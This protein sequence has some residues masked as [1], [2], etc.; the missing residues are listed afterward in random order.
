MRALLVAA[1]LVAS[2][3]LP[4]HA[5]ARIPPDSAA[6]YR[7]QEFVGVLNQGDS[8][9][10][11][12][13]ISQN[14]APASLERLPLD[15]F[16]QWY[17][18][19][20]NRTRGVD[21]IRMES[22]PTRADALLRGHLF[23]GWETLGL[24]LEPKPP[25]RII[26]D[27]TPDLQAPTSPSPPGTDR[28]RVE[29]L[30]SVLR[31]LSDA[32]AFSGVVLLARADSVLF[33]IA[34]GPED[35]ENDRPNQMDTR[36][37]LG[38]ITKS[39]TAVAVAQL[40]EA[41]KLS[42]D[43]PLTTYFPHFPVTGAERVL[44][45]HLLSHTSGVADNIRVC[46]RVKDCPTHPRTIDDYVRQVELAQEETLLFRP[47]TAWNYSN[48]N[49]DLLG[50][51][52]ELVSGEPYHEY[53]QTHIFRPAGMTG[54][55]LFRP[56]ELPSRLAVPYDREFVRGAVRLLPHRFDAAQI[57]LGSPDGGAYATAADLLR[58]ARALQAGKLVQPA[59]VELLLSPKPELT[60]PDW[61]FGFQVNPRM[62]IAGHGGTWVGV[63]AAL[64]MFLRSGYTAVVL[65]NVSYGREPTRSQVRLLIPT[66]A[67]RSP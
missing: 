51:I 19:L 40:A 16:V 14:F 24:E 13:Y 6:A 34:Y 15:R 49:F 44:I 2:S 61:G 42:F 55:G 60:A 65:S 33:G 36:F 20:Y 41:G 59:T 30:R 17:G 31:T 11:R 28:E 38:S 63:S 54:A 23:G 4:L 45:R 18:E 32:E 50:K 25:H 9:A 56:G 3:T 8:G 52:V 35:A 46:D 7:L 12:D 58:F 53:I 21:L 62:G 29:R 57:D 48:S 37:Q 26:R 10:L 1:I 43:D 67:G 64:D 39:F 47:G 22:T 5:Q 27:F 66:Q